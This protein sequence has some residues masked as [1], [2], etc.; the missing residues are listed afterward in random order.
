MNRNSGSR[1]KTSPDTGAMSPAFL[2]WAAPISATTPTTRS[3]RSGA[4][5]ASVPFEGHERCH[6]LA[7]SADFCGAA[8]LGQIDH[9]ETAHDLRAGALEKLDRGISRA[10][11]RDQIVDDDDIV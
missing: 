6:F 8:Q 11:G 9:E 7:E 4:N 10:A 2:I 5:A 3:Y 1:K